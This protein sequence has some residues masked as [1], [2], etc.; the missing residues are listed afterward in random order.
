MTSAARDLQRARALWRHLASVLREETDAVHPRL[1]IALGLMTVLP[2]FV[3]NR[4]RVV[5]L[6]WARVPIG[7]GTVI[8]GRPTIVGNAAQHDNLSFGQGC[9][10]N[11]GCH[12]DASGRIEVGHRVSIGQQVMILTNSHDIANA[13][14]R[15][16]HNHIRSV[17]IHDGAW[18]GTRCTVLPGVVIG[19]GSVVA[20]GAVVTR[21]V[22]P[23]TLVGGVPA[24]FIRSLADVPPVSSEGLAS[25]GNAG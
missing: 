17:V 12:F 23:N 25:V 22:E 6:R 19:A 24:R 18:L 11:A 8:W 20:A 21:S 14:Q 1:Q 9:V 15:A 16:G 3:G 4:L 10:V 13:D 2:Q 5:L 7:H